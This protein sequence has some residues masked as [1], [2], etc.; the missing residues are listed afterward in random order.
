MPCVFIDAQ[1]CRT[2]GQI[3]PAMFA[4]YLLILLGIVSLLWIGY[5]AIEIVETKGSLS[6]GAVFGQEDKRILIV[7]RTNELNPGLIGFTPTPQ[8]E[9]VIQTLL[10][11]LNNQ[12]TI[13]MSDARSHFMLEKKH[14]W[15]AEEVRKLCEKSGLKV[16]E[17]GLRSFKV[18]GFNL[19]YL[20]DYLYFSRGEMT[21]TA[22]LGW[23]VFD[24]KSSAA[25]ITFGSSGAEISD[26]YA[27]D[28]GI[29]EFK[30]KNERKIKGQQV[31]DAEVFLS[32]IPSGINSYHFYEKEYRKS[33]D[34][35]YAN[36]PMCKWSAT[37]YVEVAYKGST[38]LISDYIDG[39]DPLQLLYELLRK[40][41]EQLE[42]AQ[43]TG[44]KLTASFPSSMSLGFHAYLM[45]DFVVLA[46]NQAVCEEIVAAYKMGNTLQRESE[47]FRL[48]FGDLPRKVSERNYGATSHF[49][50]SI[51]RDRVLQTMVYMPEKSVNTA[52][53]G[54]PESFTMHV[55]DQIAD[56]LVDAGNGNAFVLSSGGKVIRFKGGQKAW[57]R[58]VSGRVIGQVS[59]VQTE[60][61]GFIFLVT[62]STKIVAFKENGDIVKGFPISLQGKTA[63]TG[64]CA[65]LSGNRAFGVLV[66]T[67]GE[68]LTINM[69]GKVVSSISTGITSVKKLP[70]VWLSQGKVLYGI[71][72]ADRY[73]I[74][75]ADRRRELRTISFAGN[76]A[77]SVK[78]NELILISAEGNR[79]V[80]FDQKGNPTELASSSS[81]MFAAYDGA[82]EIFAAVSPGRI[83]AFD[84]SLSSIGGFVTDC[85]AV[86]SVSACRSST[87]TVVAVIDGLENNVYLFRLTGDKY[88]ERRIEGSTKCLLHNVG[89]NLR[90]TTIVDDYLIQYTL[91]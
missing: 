53:E 12:F 37:G 89:V 58:R 50:K 91:D 55:D 88:T 43:F 4:R 2:F 77:V 33:L 6:P 25:L 38:A 29:V 30:T 28:G 65:Y 44:I 35:D 47:R 57:E 61:D 39:Q 52:D 9:K 46:D 73:S 5:V 60:R 63:S 11:Q 76:A 24:R 69:S 49:S 40:D 42:H 14:G 13:Y 72:S 87:G 27:R 26:V 82:R 51:Y 45:G 18:H 16:T 34:E 68:L 48:I 15:S 81:N 36:G 22:V 70:E 41:P 31:D 3:T 1:H 20:R 59:S 90:L 56:F 86:E 32:A 19:R 78:G 84:R 80:R 75:E 85:S 8:V 23:T 74:Y 64:A 79:L 17:N 71:Q 66:T 62:T 10:P 54:A 67:A 83:D 7:N 21:T